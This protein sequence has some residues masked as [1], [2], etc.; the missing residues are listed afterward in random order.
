MAFAV[1]NFFFFFGAK[2]KLVIRDVSGSKVLLDYVRKICIEKDSIHCEFD[3]GKTF[4][5]AS[6]SSDTKGQYTISNVDF[7]NLVRS[8]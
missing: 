8:L 3:N 5:I 1:G 2:M 4:S 7:D 6:E